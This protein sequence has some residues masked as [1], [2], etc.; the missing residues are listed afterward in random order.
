MLG[1]IHSMKATQ[2]YFY[3]PPKIEG[4][5]G[6]DVSGGDLSGGDLSGNPPIFPYTYIIYGVFEEGENPN[7]YWCDENQQTE[8]PPVLASGYD[9]TTAL[10][11]GLAV[12]VSGTFY[13]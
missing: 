1:L 2:V 10:R 8:S 12:V 9:G 7:W 3:R 6:L 4:A 13:Q 5:Y 11:D